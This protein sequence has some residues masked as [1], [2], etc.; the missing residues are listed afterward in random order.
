MFWISEAAKCKT[1]ATSG[2]YTGIKTGEA[3]AQKPGSELVLEKAES[4]PEIRRL[5][6]FLKAPGCR[7]TAWFCDFLKTLSSTRREG[8]F[9]SP[10]GF[11]ASSTGNSESGEFQRRSVAGF[12]SAYA[13]T[14]GGFARIWAGGN[15]F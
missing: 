14:F 7:L 10:S 11:R 6:G 15:L 5:P 3:F 4:V 2:N 13:D 8:G 9:R 1:F 12:S